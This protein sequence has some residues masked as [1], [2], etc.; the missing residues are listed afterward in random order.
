MGEW[1]IVVENRGAP[2]EVV[3]AAHD[4][5]LAALPPM[6]AGGEVSLV[7]VGDDE[8]RRINRAHRNMDKTTD[9]LSFPQLDKAGL[10]CLQDPA[11]YVMLGDVIINHAAAARQAVEYGHSLQREA[12]FLAVHSLL[13]LLGYDHTDAD[14]EAKMFARQEEILAKLGLIR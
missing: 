1:D 12:A 10:A 9:C 6:G 11:A 8:M 13:H 5:V 2:D 4:A 14:A 7:F 3:E